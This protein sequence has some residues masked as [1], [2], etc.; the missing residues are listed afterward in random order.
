MVTWPR[1]LQRRLVIGG[2]LTLR[3]L[4]IGAAA[5]GFGF[6]LPDILVYN[7]GQKRQEKLRF[8]LA[9]ALDMLTVC[10]EA[11]QGFDAA[12]M[13]VARTLT[14]P[15]AGEFARVLQEIQ[16]GKPRGDAFSA[17]AGR[18]SQ[19][20]PVCPRSRHSSPRSFRRTV[21]DCPSGTCCQGRR[22]RCD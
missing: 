16:I 4:I 21:S 18:S 14:G 20:A 8:G 2:G 19:D 9:D 22:T 13:Q 5:A 6:F 17:L 15:V 10:V 11:G 3:G 12:I 1:A 7:A